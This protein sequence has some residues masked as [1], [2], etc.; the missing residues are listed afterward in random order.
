MPVLL[1]FIYK[2]TLLF[3]VTNA[4][5]DILVNEIAH[6]FISVDIQLGCGL[7]PEDGVSM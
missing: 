3:I 2:L 7:D 5:F 6:N 4:A 1:D